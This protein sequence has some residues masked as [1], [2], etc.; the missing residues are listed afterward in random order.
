MDHILHVLG[1]GS[2]ALGGSIYLAVTISILLG[3]RLLF[4]LRQPSAQTNYFNIDMSETTVTSELAKDPQQ[5]ATSV[6]KNLYDKHHHSLPKD[7]PNSTKK[8]EIN[9][10]EDA[11]T[12]G[13][14]GSAEP[15][16]LFLQVST[17]SMKCVYAISKK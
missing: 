9:G 8:D 2:T 17:N 6:F 10:I 3:I 11:R 13:R 1:R 15:S 4:S 16:E 7:L 12:H 14:W 5:S